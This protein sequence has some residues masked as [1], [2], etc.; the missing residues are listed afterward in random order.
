M[1]KR[2]NESDD[3]DVQF[4]AEKKHEPASAI[5]LDESGDNDNDENDEDDD[6]SQRPSGA[7]CLARCKQFAS[8]T[9][10]DNAL[11]M[12]YLQENDWDVEVTF[13]V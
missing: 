8:V 3:D 10:T 1:N 6:D 7:E 9:N 12:F 11:A 4:V 13:R 5:E 2:E